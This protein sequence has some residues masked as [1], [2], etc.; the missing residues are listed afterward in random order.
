MTREE[1]ADPTQPAG[2]ERLENLRYA[3]AKKTSATTSRMSPITTEMASINT[4]AMAKT[5]KNANIL[6][7][8]LRSSG[9]GAEEAREPIV[10]RS[11]RPLV[12]SVPPVRR[13][14]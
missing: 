14:V 7:T 12:I 11:G 2:G 13:K 3:T 6:L 1:D 5:A 4:P 9:D 10:L 8:L